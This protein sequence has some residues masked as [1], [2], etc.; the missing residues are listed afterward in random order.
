MNSMREITPWICI[1][2]AREQRLE[3][4]EGGA[5]RATQSEGTGGPSGSAA[6]VS[7]KPSSSRSDLFCVHAMLMLCPLIK[8]SAN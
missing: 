8:T 6:Q 5:P 1:F 4:S 7:G 2:P 3:L